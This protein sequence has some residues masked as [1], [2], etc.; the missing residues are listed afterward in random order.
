MSGI[1]VNS[2]QFL[3]EAHVVLT[4]ANASSLLINSMH[5]G[6]TALGA[7]AIVAAARAPRFEK[8]FWPLTFALSGAIGAAAVLVSSPR[9]WFS[10]F[11][12]AYWQAGEAIWR[13]P[14]ALLEVFERGVN[15]FVNLPIVAYLFAPFGL[16]SEQ[17]AAAVF[18]LLGAVAL[19][20]SWFLMTR[21]FAL[22]R[23]D[24][25][26]LLL[27]LAAFGPIIYSVRQG[28][29]SHHLLALLLLGF[30]AIR[31]GRETIGGM[32]FGLAAVM[33][34]PLLV[35]GFAYALRAKWKVV[36]G[37]LLICAG[38][39]LASL[40]VFG[41]ELHRSWYELV[42][43]PYAGQPVA[44]L[45]AQSVASFV[46]RL[47]TGLPGIV[48][49]D[50]VTLSPLAKGAVYLISALLA[51]LCVAAC[52]RTKP[53]PEQMEIEALLAIT[54]VCLVSTLTWSHYFAWFAPCFAI[55]LARREELGGWKWA[56]LGGFILAAPIEFLSPWMRDGVYGPFTNLLTSHLTI[57]A[58]LVFFTLARLRYGPIAANPLASPTSTSPSTRAGA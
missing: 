54:L 27:A 55:F 29:S 12:L 41:W 33:K 36:A 30:A 53:S 8:L 38:F 26:L 20:G 19:L 11:K 6:L 9:I 51:L 48:D 7:F 13:G 39:A 49:W 25:A 14:E 18:F 24:S 10:D 52:W 43:E 42:I 22:S 45:N 32:L 1:V 35:L 17:A 21:M 47:Q 34:P 3:S 2:L 57:A 50:P 44:A 46:A 28:N 56:A 15:G 23:R 31:G 16:L 37:G 4:N 5:L 58:L 40:A